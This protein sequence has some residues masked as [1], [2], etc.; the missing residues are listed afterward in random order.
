MVMQAQS[1]WV[2]PQQQS[3]HSNGNGYMGNG[4]YYGGGQQHG[5]AANGVGGNGKVEGNVRRFSSPSGMTGS[6]SSTYRRKDGRR[7]K[8]R[9]R[10]LRRYCYCYF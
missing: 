5:Y 10:C 6:T 1:G 9:G 3:L 2:P 7:G 4:G 8:K